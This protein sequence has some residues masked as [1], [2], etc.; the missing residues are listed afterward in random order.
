MF[1][2]K[3]KKPDF[4]A[5]GKLCITQYHLYACSNNGPELSLPWYIGPTV[6]T[7]FETG[8]LNALQQQN[9]KN[10]MASYR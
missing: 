9:K 7:I 6:C 10:P 5:I 8:S 1:I 4:Y 2:K 3:L